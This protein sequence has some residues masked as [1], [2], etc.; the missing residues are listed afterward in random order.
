M[1]KSVGVKQLNLL[2]MDPA[3]EIGYEF[4]SRQCMN[5]TWLGLLVDER[6]DEVSRCL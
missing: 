2:W 4:G 1:E 6:I 5:L 3:G